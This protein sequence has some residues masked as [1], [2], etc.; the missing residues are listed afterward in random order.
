MKY[1]GILI[2]SNLI[3]KNHI[4]HVASKITI[5]TIRIL[6]QNEDILYKEVLKFNQENSSTAHTR[7]A[8]FSVVVVLL[9]T[10]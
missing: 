7:Y 8:N 9:F 10:P 3:W 5:K 4:S 1:L 6:F 2:D